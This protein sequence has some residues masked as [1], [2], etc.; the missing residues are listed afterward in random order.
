MVKYRPVKAE[1]KTNL[2]KIISSK[3]TLIPL[4]ALD[5]L[6]TAWYFSLPNASI[7]M[8][9]NPLSRFFIENYGMPGAFLEHVA[10]TGICFGFFALLQKLEAKNNDNS[11]KDIHKTSRRLIKIANMTY[12]LVISGNIA[13]VFV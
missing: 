10:T 4:S 12:P 7:S 8:E 9:G 6:T 1:I 13:S 3:Y 5:Y 2:E 11:S